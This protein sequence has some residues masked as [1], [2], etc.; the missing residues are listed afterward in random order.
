MANQVPATELIKEVSRIKPYYGIHKEYDLSSFLR[1][2]EII[3]P[4]FDDNPALKQFIFEKH[5]WT[6]LQEAALQVKRT[7]GPSA[8]LN[9]INFRRY[10]MGH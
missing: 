3:L 4:L 9:E 2:I 1:E 8:I 6:K 5:I 10:Q 7:L